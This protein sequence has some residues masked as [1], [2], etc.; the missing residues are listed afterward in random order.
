M[1]SALIIVQIDFYENFKHNGSMQKN[2]MERKNILIKDGEVFYFESLFSEEES[3]CLLDEFIDRIQWKSETIQLFGKSILQPRL[4][5]YYGE[6]K[7]YTYSGRKME[8]L[9]FTEALKTVKKRVE[10]Y[11]NISFTNVLLNYYRNENDSMGWHRDNEK[12]LGEDP[13]IASVSFGSTR[14]FKFQHT[15]DKSLKKDIFLH[16]GSLLLMRGKTQTFWKHCLPKQR[17]SIGPRINLTFR[18]LK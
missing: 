11:S 6:D 9:P 15:L 2:L 7:S 12:T 10:N 5:A 14:L 13:I 1:Y 18:V 17:K 3:R 4:T 16:N 8:A